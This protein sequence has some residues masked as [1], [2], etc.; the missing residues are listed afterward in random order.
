DAISGR[1]GGDTLYGGGDDDT[2][3]GFGGSDTLYGG[4]GSDRF[5]ITD[6]HA[7]NTIFGGETGSD[8]D[9]VS[10]SNF[11]STEGVSITATGDEA[12]TFDFIA[13]GAN[14]TGTFEGVEAFDATDFGDMVDLSASGAAQTVDGG[15]GND[16][17]TGGTGA[18]S[19]TGGTGNDTA[20]GGAGADDVD[21]GAGDDHV[22]SGEGNDTLS[23]GTGNDTVFADGGD[24]TAFGGAGNDDVA[25]G[26]GADLLY[27]GDGNDTVNGGAGSDADTLYGGAGTDTLTGRLGD[28]LVY[29]GDDADTFV[30]EGGFGADTLYG[31]EGGIDSDTLDLSALGTGVTV[32]FTSDEAGTFTDGTDTGQFFGFENVI[33]S[34]QADIVDAGVES[35]DLILDTAGGDDSVTGGSGD[36]SLSGADGDDSLAGGSGNDLIYGG[37]GADTLS[38]GTGNDTLFGGAGE[39]RLSNS[40]GN[41][42]LYGGTGNDDIVA[43]LGDDTLYGG[44]GNDTLDGG[45]DDDVLYGGADDDTLTGGAGADTLYGGA[46]TDTFDGPN[47]AGDVVVGGED[48][49]RINFGAGS[50]TVTVTGNEAGSVVGG[51]TFSE[52][53]EFDLGAGDDTLTADAGAVSAGL[54]VFGGAGNDSILGGADEDALYGG[55]GNDNIAGEA[56]NDLLYG[57]AGNDTLT[58]G[59]G[60][61][62]LTGGAGNDTFALS[63]G[64]GDDTITDFDAA[65]SGQTVAQGTTNYALANDR[66]DTSTLS[67]V[68]NALTNQDGTVTADEVVVTGGGGGPQLLTFP[69]GETVQ[70][71]DG[72]VDTTTPQTQFASL[73]AMGVPPCFAP[74]T[75]ILTTRGEIPVENLCIGDLVITADRGP[76]PLRWMGKRTEVF[77]S[78]DDPHIPTLITAGSLGNGLPGRNL[79]IS[80]LHRV[81]LSGPGIEDAF[82]APEILA[83]SKAL[84]LQPGIRRMKGKRRIDYYSLL[85]DRHEVIFSEGVPTESFRPGPIALAGFQEHVKEQIYAIYPDLKQHPEDGLGPPARLIV[86]RQEIRQH[87]KMNRAI[88]AFSARGRAVEHG[89]EA[90]LA[91]V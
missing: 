16:V 32:T 9:T 1:N 17:L 30:V 77:K 37:D 80:P 61:D 65:D 45:V 55:T 59:A 76:Q 48:A 14:A 40:S 10:F 3:S 73:V 47:D 78:R 21:G 62:V 42:I 51:G 27:G 67:D 68:G 56:G 31:G 43:T 58:G 22:Q 7:G 38:T 19:L 50:Q 15:A 54:S 18:D 86:G 20:Y 71:A 46:G 5:Q 79:I 39:D 66:L 88:T 64:G 23:G 82:G 63:A 35:I 81:V 90:H 13:A 6:D 33:V 91:I 11:A 34:D 26:Q 24:D 75:L 72:T 84:T 83:L 52:I 53:E 41:D 29:G 8:V 28:D 12:G 36:D 25:G 89:L 2:L 70:V 49:D 85:F 74:G 4:E 57:G 60:D 87:I 69:S 44:D